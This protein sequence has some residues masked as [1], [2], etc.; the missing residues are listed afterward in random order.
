MQRIQCSLWTRYQYECSSLKSITLPESV[1][2]I[3]EEAFYQAGLKSITFPG[4]ISSIGKRAF[5][6]C[7]GLETVTFLKPV[8]CEQ[9]GIA[10]Y[11]TEEFTN[12][13]FSIQSKENITID[14]LG[15]NWAEPLYNWANDKSAVTA[16]RICMNDETHTETETVQARPEITKEA[17]CTE[18]GEITYTSN[19]F[20][21]ESFTIQTLKIAINKNDNHKW[22]EPVYFWDEDN[23]TVIATRLCEYNNEHIETETVNSTYS[24]TKQPTCTEKGET[25]FTSDNFTNP[26]FTIQTRVIENIN[27]IGHIWSE[28]IYVWNSNNTQVTAIRACANDVSHRETEKASVNGTLIVSPTDTEEG[29]AAYN[30]IFQ[31]EAFVSQIKILP[32][33]A[34]NNLSKLV[35]PLNITT[36]GEEA[37]SGAI[38]EAVIIPEGCE[39][40]EGRAFAEC[41]QLKYV[42]I[43]QSVNAI[44]QDA[45]DGCLAV[46][47]D[48]GEEQ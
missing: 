46:I 18:E 29:L 13:C 36:L 10:N 39:K 7:G 19:S 16:E 28:P 2:S 24:V 9:T 26:A 21:N 8:E 17:T 31:N 47:L 25:T 5:S 22:E 1:T 11:T 40:I 20:D 38:F 42:R 48:Y 34:L 14:A 3:G 6:Y 43:P 44:A 35:L 30:A 45:F 37:F 33:Q 27:A 41:K 12:A 15:H 4:N 32:I 23:Y